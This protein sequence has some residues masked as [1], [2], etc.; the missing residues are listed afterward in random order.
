MVGT[1]IMDGCETVETT[2]EELADQL[3]LVTFDYIQE[4]L[5]TLHNKKVTIRAIEQ[6]ITDHKFKVAK[7][8]IFK[9]LA[10][11]ISVKMYNVVMQY[12]RKERYQDEIKKQIEWLF[13]QKEEYFLS[14]MEIS[15]LFKRFYV[16]GRINPLFP[17]LDFATIKRNLEEF[18]G[19][20]DGVDHN[21]VLQE[22]CDEWGYDYND[23]TIKDY[24]VNKEL[25][26]EEDASHSIF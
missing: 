21:T 20:Y 23:T 22:F 10:T 6:S 4:R 13:D 16:K 14:K 9:N 24:Y 25:L 17:P 11:Q 18:Y 1:V 26:E 19:L 12:L 5:K 8:P 15:A 2:P 3:G 7:R